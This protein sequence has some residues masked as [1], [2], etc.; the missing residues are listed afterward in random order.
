MNGEQPLP[1]PVIEESLAWHSYL[2]HAIAAVPLLLTA[3]A[4]SLLLVDP[5]VLDFAMFLHPVNVPTNVMTL[6][7]LP[8]VVIHGQSGTG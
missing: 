4:P 7:T 5:T 8:S 1:L 6:L 2:P 3:V